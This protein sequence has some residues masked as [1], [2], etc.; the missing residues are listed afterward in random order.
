ML[1]HPAG[2]DS[3][4]LAFVIEFA[5]F[6]LCGSD[7]NTEYKT[8]ARALL[9]NLGDAKNIKL[10]GRIRG[11]DVAADEL[12]RMST[13]ELANEE[14]QAQAAAIAAEKLHNSQNQR[15]NISATTSAQA[16]MDHDGT[17]R[18]RA[19]EDD[20]ARAPAEEKPATQPAAAS[21]EALERSER[22]S[23]LVDDRHL[24][25]GV[26]ASMEATTAAQSSGT[27][28]AP[29]SVDSLHTQERAIV[30]AIAALSAD[31]VAALPAAFQA[32]Y[33]AIRASLQHGGGAVS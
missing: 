22:A 15:N 20:V 6:E 3:T 1:R 4:K 33:Q 19:M 10:R 17:V 24:A 32:Q 27:A 14:A 5:L 25:A 9:Y 29:A 2:P 18:W 31:Q 21:A 23:Q 11:G 7:T 30:A 13:D 8:K 28:P 26:G 16:T 12:V